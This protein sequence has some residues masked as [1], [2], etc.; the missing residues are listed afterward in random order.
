M[1]DKPSQDKLLGG[2]FDLDLE[3]EASALESADSSALFEKKAM[4]M[5]GGSI[6]FVMKDNQLLWD[7]DEDDD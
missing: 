2:N 6:A 4:E 3:R 1:S 7:D 5:L